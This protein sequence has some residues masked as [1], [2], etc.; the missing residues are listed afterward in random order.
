MD[1]K[2]LKEANDIRLYNT[3]AYAKCLDWTLA[4]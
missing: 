1:L 3:P 2:K 4:D